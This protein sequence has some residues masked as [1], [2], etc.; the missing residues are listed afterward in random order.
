MNLLERALGHFSS[1]PGGA[2]M[3]VGSDAGAAALVL[4]AGG[5]PEERDEHWQH[6]NL[7]ALGRVTTFLSVGPAPV[8]EADSPMLPAALALP[9][10]LPGYQRIVTING[11]L[12]APVH[13]GNAAG[14][15]CG[16]AAAARATP[17]ATA[18]SDATTSDADLRFALL[19]RIFGESAL[20]LPL[21]G[22]HAIEWINICD[23]RFGSAYP[24]LHLQLA[25]GA[26]VNLV[27]R[28]VGSVDPAALVCTDLTVALGEA[29]ALT[30]TRLL[31]PTDG[32]LLLDNL[33]A[34]LAA[35][36]IYRVDQIAAGQAQAR[37]TCI[38]DL[39]GDSSEL[40][41]NGVAA[42]SAGDGFDA[43]VRVTHRGKATRTTH[44]F[45]GICV[46][47]A[48]L[49]C[50]ADVR[51]LASAAGARVAQSLRA[52]N[53]GAGTH[54][55]LRPRLTIETDDIQASHG[56]TTGQLDENLLFY[57][58]SRGID[59]ATAR[60]LLK[61]AFLEDVL[62][63]IA[64]PALRHQAEQLA[65]TQLAEVAALDLQS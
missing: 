6:A 48:R 27:E 58:L 36:A 55:S 25:A 9:T 43:L 65:A 26:Q 62:A 13:I 24:R 4:R 1:R 35:R 39:L 18:L 8:R 60:S 16:A 53:D 54:V 15:A 20:S 63:G 44:R 29:A 19:A 57:L 42:V 12:V 28:L 38:V 64:P 22:Q 47:N 32:S 49:G 37:S 40:H 46:G 2:S 51:V 41:W 45:R 31:A 5:L 17:A 10:P 56:A 21:T 3:L 33:S 50:D 59:P 14:V 34:T 30:H 23:A 7:K 52:L 11:H 61:W